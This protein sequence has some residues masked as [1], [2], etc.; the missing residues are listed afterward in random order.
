MLKERLQLKR[1]LKEELAQKHEV[2]LSL[3]SRIKWLS[4]FSS[5]LDVPGNIDQALVL[6]LIRLYRELHKIES[7]KPEQQVI[8]GIL[9]LYFWG[10]MQ[11]LRNDSEI[12]AKL[13]RIGDPFSEIYFAYMIL[14]AEGDFEK[15]LAQDENIRK[16]FYEEVREFIK[17]EFKRQCRYKLCE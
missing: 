14:M 16:A 10:D 15:C 12:R 9:L 17:I 11:F 4:S 8:L 13:F 7:T 5:A 3:K 1:E 2:F 6:K